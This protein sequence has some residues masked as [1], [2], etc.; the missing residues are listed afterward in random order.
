MKRYRPIKTLYAENSIFTAL[1]EG[2]DEWK[3]A[4]YEESDQQCVITGKKV[5]LDIHHI[6]VKFEDLVNE[7]HHNLNIYYRK[8]RYDYST[9]EIEELQKEVLRLHFQYGLGVAIYRP[10]HKQYHFKYRNS[11]NTQTFH[12]FSNSIKF[13]EQLLPN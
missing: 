1:R 8:N 9:Y 2:L 6:S 13:K 3:K 10:I 5:D 12:E 4:S 7:A 11:I